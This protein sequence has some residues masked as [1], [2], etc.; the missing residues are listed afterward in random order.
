[1]IMV[2]NAPAEEL[3]QYTGRSLSD[4][5]KAL[6]EKYRDLMDAPQWKPNKPRD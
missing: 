6:V 1:M 4:E 2:V 5:E 3:P